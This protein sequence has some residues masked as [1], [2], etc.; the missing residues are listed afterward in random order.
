MPM[1]GSTLRPYLQ[2]LSST[3]SWPLSIVP[4]EDF[5]TIYGNLSSKARFGEGKREA[6]FSMIYKMRK[7]AAW[8]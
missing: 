3:L 1:P 7:E 5:G 8:R 6:I 2:R 4:V